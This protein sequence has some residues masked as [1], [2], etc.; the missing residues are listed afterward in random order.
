[1]V[2][3][4]DRDLW[5]GQCPSGH[6]K[7]VIVPPFRLFQQGIANS[8][9]WIINS[10]KLFLWSEENLSHQFLHASHYSKLNALLFRLRSSLLKSSDRQHGISKIKLETVHYLYCPSELC[11]QH[12]QYLRVFLRYPGKDRRSCCITEAWEA[13]PTVRF[14][15]ARTTREGGISIT[16][17]NHLARGIKRDKRCRCS[18]LLTAGGWGPLYPRQSPVWTWKHPCGHHSPCPFLKGKV[19]QATESCHCTEEQWPCLLYH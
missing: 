17:V 6:S 3:V 13:F 1:M 4:Q 2:P 16:G 19:K 5:K 10:K 9:V 12:W 18:F 7:E 15:A 11:G 8:R 14:K